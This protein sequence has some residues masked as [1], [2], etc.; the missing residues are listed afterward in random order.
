MPKLASF[1]YCEIS[2]LIKQTIHHVDDVLT[3]S[4]VITDI[5]INQQRVTKIANIIYKTCDRVCYSVKLIIF[6]SRMCRQTLYTGTPT[7]IIPQ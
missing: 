7:K 2:N 5:Y 6:T 1:I 3:L 4:K